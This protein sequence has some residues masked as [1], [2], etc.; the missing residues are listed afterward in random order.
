MTEREPTL[1][2]VGDLGHHAHRGRPVAEIS[3]E[4]QA[5]GLAI[6]EGVAERQPTGRPLIGNRYWADMPLDVIVCIGALVVTALCLLLVLTRL[7]YL[8]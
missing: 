5:T 1:V 7:P 2:V 4:A 8:P 6:A 3:V